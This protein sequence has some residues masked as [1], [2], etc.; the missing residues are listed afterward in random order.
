MISE[1]GSGA[2]PSR[3]YYFFR[4]RVE[5]LERPSIH[6]SYRKSGSEKSMFTREVVKDG[7]G[8]GMQYG[9]CLSGSPEHLHGAL[10]VCL[11]LLW[12]RRN[13]VH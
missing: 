12:A 9:C 7:C 3:F 8:P 13:Q 5:G 6:Q 11:G 10:D 2:T 4:F 1:G